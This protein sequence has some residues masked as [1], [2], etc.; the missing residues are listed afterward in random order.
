MPLLYEAALAR[1]TGLPR[2]NFTIACDQIL[3]QIVIEKGLAL[4]FNTTQVL[5]SY[6]Y[7]HLWKFR[8]NL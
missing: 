2:F 6:Y 8:I 3:P 7:P 5:V 4:D 1:F